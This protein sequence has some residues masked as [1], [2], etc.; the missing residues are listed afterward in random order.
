[1]TTPPSEQ[2]AAPIVLLCGAEVVVPGG[3]D[4]GPCRCVKHTGHVPSGNTN[5]EPD[6]DHE[7]ACGARWDDPTEPNTAEPTPDD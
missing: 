4:C 7:C 1:M 6:A 5:W 3:G 2:A